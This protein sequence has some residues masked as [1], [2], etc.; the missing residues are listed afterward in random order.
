MKTILLVEDDPFISD[1]YVTRFKNENFAVDVAGDGQ[2][3]L[4]KIRHSIPDLLTLDIDLPKVNGCEM[5]KILKNDPKTRNLKIIVLSNYTD[6]NIKEKYDVNLADFNIIKH[7]L[8]IETPIEEIVETI[9][10]ALN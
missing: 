7:F 9:K 8:K 5:L 4:D 2:I 1:V 10:E 6:E 3:A